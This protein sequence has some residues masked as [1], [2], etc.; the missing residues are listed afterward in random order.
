MLADDSSSNQHSGNC[1]GAGSSLRILH[2]TC[3]LPPTLAR[4]G[5][6]TLIEIMEE[7]QQCLRHRYPCLLPYALDRSLRIFV[8]FPS[9]AVPSMMLCAHREEPCH[10][11]LEVSRPCC[12]WRSWSVEDQDVAAPS[13]YLHRLLAPLW[14][15]LSRS[16]SFFLSPLSLDETDCKSYCY[17]SGLCSR[18][19]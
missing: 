3:W 19:S 15:T 7:A 4:S 2:R 13:A 12:P 8:P 5:H 14:P 6:G 16:C 17:C 10:S 9:A 1:T 18:W 11:R